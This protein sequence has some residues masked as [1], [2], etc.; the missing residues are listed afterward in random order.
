MDVERQRGAGSDGA[1]C[2]GRVAEVRQCH[3]AATEGANLN[4]GLVERLYRYGNLSVFVAH[5]VDARHE[6]CHAH[7]CVGL[8]ELGGGIGRA[9]GDGVFAAKEGQLPHYHYA[10]VLVALRNGILGKTL[11]GE[12]MLGGLQYSVCVVI[13]ESYYGE[14]VDVPIVAHVNVVNG[15]AWDSDRFAPLTVDCGAQ[16]MVMVVVG[17]ERTTILLHSVDVTL[18]NPKLQ[19]VALHGGV[20]DDFSIDA[21]SG[22]VV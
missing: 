21:E 16:H 13:Y 9:I 2:A 7:G 17:I 15:V 14:I 10:T 18:G 3:L 4:H 8:I 19:V 1:R 5:E 6:T 20:G 22:A 11:V 12:M